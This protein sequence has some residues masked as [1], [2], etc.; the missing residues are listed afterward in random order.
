MAYSSTPL[1]TVSLEKVRDLSG[2]APEGT[3]YNYT[4]KS[5]NATEALRRALL[6]LKRDLPDENPVNWKAV[7]YELTPEA[8]LA[9]S[10][11]A[12]TE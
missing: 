4:Y 10:A 5:L 11:V 7:Q 12:A 2:E 8:P 1:K 9:G 6:A 3:I